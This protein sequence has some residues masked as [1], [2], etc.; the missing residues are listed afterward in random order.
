[1]AITV[2]IDNYSIDQRTLI[3]IGHDDI[4]ATDEVWDAIHPLA[5]LLVSAG[6]ADTL[7]PWAQLTPRHYQLL[8]KKQLEVY[9]DLDV[10]N[11]HDVNHT[12]VNTL[13]FLFCAYVRKVSELTGSDVDV[14]RIQKIGPTDY[15]MNVSL[16]IILATGTKKQKELKRNFKIIVDNTKDDE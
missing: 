3:L 13:R 4:V 15:S 14:I 2:I 16:N 12:V 8:I 9:M 7:L 10:V 11:Q 5:K 1:M 6:V